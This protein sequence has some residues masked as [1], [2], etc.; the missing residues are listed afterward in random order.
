MPRQAFGQDLRTY[1]VFDFRKGE[2]LKDSPLQLA[3]QR[4]QNSLRLARNCVYTASGGV[5]KRFDR[6]ILTTSSVG[7]SV[8]ITGGIR[9]TRSNADVFDIFGTDD[10]RI[11]RLNT[12]GT[13]TNQVTG[14]TTGTKWYFATYADDLIAC[15][16]ADAP[17]QFDGTTWTTLAGSPPAT[18]G[19]VAVHGNRVFFLDATQL[20][21]LT[22]SALG[23]N[24]DYTTANNAG[25]AQISENDGSTCIDLIPSINELI[26]LKGS[27]P[28]RLQGTSPSTYALTNLVPT[29]G[30]KGAISTKGNVFAV[31]DVWF[32]ADSGVMNLRTVLDFGD[33]KA[34]FSSD[35]ISP[36][37]E[38]GNANTVTI[39]NLDDAVCAYDSQNN[40]IYWCLDSDGN[41]QNDLL[42][43]LDL[44][45]NGW[46]HWTAQPFASMWPVKNTSNGLVEIYTG[47]YDG[48]IRVLNRDVTTNTIDG[49]AQHLS[50]LG[51]PGV[52]KSPRHAYFYFKEDGNYTVVIDTKFDFGATGGQTYTASLLGGTRTLGVDW[53]L[54]TDPLGSRD[55]ITR[56]VDLSGVGE[57]LQVGVRNQNANEPFTWYGYECLW[58]P[59]RAVRPSTTAV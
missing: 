54:G 51:E 11:I 3:I 18:G 28:F 2:N 55:Q 52:Q 50:A 41:D 21:R 34:S 29:T 26:I 31:N 58:R 57:F 8:R 37:F 45:T 27:R 16:R 44:H 59:R 19:P 38:A 46:S 25:S 36:R 30:S 5:T 35:R 20:S 24:D 23:T 1:S 4:G 33:L 42:L 47:G 53:T 7:A 43:C 14:L 32:L 17:R 10:G 39:Q 48:N 22:W 9:F 40:R 49:Y 56:R 15:N 13:T 6:T 12:D